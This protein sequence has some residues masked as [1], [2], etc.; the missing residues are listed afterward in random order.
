[1]ITIHHDVVC[2]Y[3]YISVP[4]V[5]EMHGPTDV[6]FGSNVS[7]RCTVLE[8]YPLPSVSI[9]TP[10][11]DIINQSVIR[12]NATMNDAGDYSCIANNSLA[13]VTRNLTLTVY[14]KFYS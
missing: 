6:K 12:F 10:Q 14:G 3:V 2:T 11:G 7:I 1:M 13:T 9:I 8:G 4:P 5:V